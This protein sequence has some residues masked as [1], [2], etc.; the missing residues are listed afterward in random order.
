MD[1]GEPGHSRQLFIQ[2]RVVLHRARAERVESGV[3][4]IVL[5]RQPREVTHNLRLAQARQTDRAPPFETA[6]PAGER[7]WLGEIDAAM[8]RQILLENQRLFDLQTAV[9]DHAFVPLRLGRARTRQRAHIVH[10]STS[11]KPS[12][13]RSISASVVSSVATSSRRFASSPRC[14]K[15]RL[16]G[17]P[18]RMPLSASFSTTSA[19]GRDSLIEN[20]LKKAWLTSRIPGTASSRSASLTAAA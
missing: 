17:T 4:R 16:T 11:R 8:T 10:D 18:A 9:A 5:L 12:L 3:D 19:A 2:A 6:Q 1:V 15:K 13:S 14:G 7:G 20:S